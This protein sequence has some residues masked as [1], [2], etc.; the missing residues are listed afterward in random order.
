MQNSTRLRRMTTLSLLFALAMIFS[1]VE[2]RLPT[3]IPVPGVK[4]GLCNVVIIFTLLRLGA[5]SA[6]AVSL[7]RVILS[8]ILFGN[9][10]AFFYSLAGAV[11]SLA[12]MILFSRLRLFSAVGISVLG[13]V[14]HNIGQLLM[15]WIILGTAGVL[16]YLPVL[17]IAGTV[18]GI[19]IGLLAA[20]LS[21]RA[22][23]LKL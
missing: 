3:F 16:Y 15:A 11:L 13:G 17:L 9:A 5:P 20:Y 4:L 18:A 7:L 14:M 22:E 8:S 12:A 23:S 2:S 21:K 19:L 10:A 6:I 1:F